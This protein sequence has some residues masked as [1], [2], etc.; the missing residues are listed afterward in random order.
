MKFKCNSCQHVFEHE[1]DKN[2]C[3]CPKCGNISRRTEEI[4]EEQSA[5][6]SECGTI[7]PSDSTSCPVCGCPIS[8]TQHRHCDE[9]GAEVSD[10]AQVVLNADAPFQLQYPHRHLESSTQMRPESPK[11][12]RLTSSRR[13]PSIPFPIARL[14]RISKRNTIIL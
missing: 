3:F 6:C 13:T 4:E 2:E 12:L 9:C 10:S 7:I 14:S 8:A 11:S 5:V 1:A